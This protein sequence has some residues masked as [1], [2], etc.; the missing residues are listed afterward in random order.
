MNINDVYET[1][2]Y[3]ITGFQLFRKEKNLSLS[4][5]KYNPNYE[6]Y[7]MGY[8]EQ[9]PNIISMK[10]GKDKEFVFHKN[11]AYELFCAIRGKDEVLASGLTK[12]IFYNY[13]KKNG[14]LNV[15]NDNLL[16]EGFVLLVRKNDMEN[17]PKNKK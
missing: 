5:I 15:L 7:Q 16:G 6:E 13:C 12:E 1:E 10:Y 4:T 9:N 11:N 8:S 3:G 14:L 2:C 17:Y